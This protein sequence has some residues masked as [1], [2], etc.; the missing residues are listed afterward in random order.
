M[1]LDLFHCLPVLPLGIVPIIAASLIGAGGSIAASVI[2]STLG[3]KGE[4]SSPINTGDDGENYYSF[5]VGRDN[6]TG[7]GS[8]PAAAVPALAEGTLTQTLIPLAIGAVIVVTALIFTA[9]K[10]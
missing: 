1:L 5:V 3:N 6:K 4:V 9:R 8:T 2:G 10:K 7:T